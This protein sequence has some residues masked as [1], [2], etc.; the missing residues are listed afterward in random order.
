MQQKISNQEK[1]EMILLD[2]AMPEMDGYE[3]TLWL[4]A[5]YPDIKILVMSVNDSQETL[6]Q[7]VK[8]GVNGFVLKESDLEEIL[9]AFREIRKYGYYFSSR[10]QGH[11]TAIIKRSL[12]PQPSLAEAILLNQQEKRFLELLCTELSYNEICGIMHISYHTLDNYRDAIYRKLNVKSRT[13]S[14][15]YAVKH[16]LVQV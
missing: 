7:M 14:V 3:C 4:K 2:I 16:G 12:L 6:Y 1:P 10:M 15:L 5:H 8:A 11:L 9:R 13:G